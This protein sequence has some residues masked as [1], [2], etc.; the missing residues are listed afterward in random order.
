[1]STILLKL[2]TKNLN[3]VFPDG[4]KYK[5]STFPQTNVKPVL[6]G[7]RG[8]V[9]TVYDLAASFQRVFVFVWF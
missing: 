3:V 2:G 4:G 5:T 7:S 6:Y 9:T 1:M 8:E